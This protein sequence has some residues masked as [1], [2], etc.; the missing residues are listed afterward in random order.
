VW[1]VKA[2]KLKTVALCSETVEASSF[3]A[4]VNLVC[5]NVWFDFVTVKV[6]DMIK[7]INS[8]SNSEQVVCTLM[9]LLLTSTVDTGQC[10]LA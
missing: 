3:F 9:S 6:L 4:E 8:C 7:Q 5:V 1:G 10:A 2:A